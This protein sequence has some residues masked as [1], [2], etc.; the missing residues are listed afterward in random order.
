MFGDNKKIEDLQITSKTF[1]KR[2]LDVETEIEKIKS[3]MLS[4]RGFVN[5]RLELPKED[6][7]IEE[8]K[9]E[10]SKKNGMQYL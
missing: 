4:L 9:K 6:D 1:E 10:K 8:T 7:P 5:R 2:M 3:Q